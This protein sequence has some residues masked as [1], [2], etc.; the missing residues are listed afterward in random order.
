MLTVAYCRVSTEEQAAEG[1]SIEGQAEKLKTYAELHD[2]GPVTVISDPGRSGK[3]LNRAGLQQLLAM[4]DNGHVVNVLTWRLDRLSRNLAD[5]ILLAD[6]FGQSGVAL[7]S[8]TERLDLSSATGRMFYNI[9]GSFAQFYREQLAENVRMGM[10]QAA[11]QGKWVN[12]PKTGYDL[13]DGEL[14]PN[15]M[16]NVVR[17]IFRLRGEGH[18]QRDIESAT[19]VNYSTVLAILHS[20]IY[21]GEV[22]L[23]GEWFPGRHE[24]IIT[25]EE[26]EAAHRGRVKGRRKGKDMLSGKV[27]CGMCHRLMAIEINGSGRAM[28]RCRHRGQGCQQPRRLNKG[29]L[30]A[31]LLGIRLVATDEGLQDAIREELG[32]VRRPS[33][34]DR[35]GPARTTVTVDALAEQRRK[36]LRLHYEDKISAE[37][38]A[39]EEDRLSRQ[40][41]AARA[42]IDAEQRA[43]E[44]LD[45]V[46]NR[47]EQVARVLRDMDFDRVWEEANGQERRVLIEELLDS[48][49]VLPDHLEVTVHGA[50]RLNVLL[51][52]VGLVESQISGVGGGT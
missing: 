10:A 26:F 46:A 19:G 42:D 23:N 15:E 49:T 27:R 35:G 25:P 21:L 37:L 3:D 22:L 1:F 39:E 2:L 44:Q 7:H 45:E 41:A 48:V 20:R 14:V 8:F 18:S 40:I 51:E 38:F 50:P 4:V 24:A 52:E 9:L 28:Y 31:A 32:Q 11:R 12:R 17:R 30:R 33:R 16:A 34:S 43:E 5:L 47:F 29:L 6:R 36:L 13:R